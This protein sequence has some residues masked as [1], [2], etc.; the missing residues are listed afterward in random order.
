MYDVTSVE[1]SLSLPDLTN[2]TSRLTAAAF[3]S[4]SLESV[5]HTTVAVSS[6]LNTMNS[7]SEIVALRTSMLGSIADAS[8]GVDVS[9]DTLNQQATSLLALTDRP[10][11]LEDAAQETALEYTRNL[12]ASSR[13]K[14]LARGTDVAIGGV[15]SNLLGTDLLDAEQLRSNTSG[16]AHDDPTITSV[17]DAVGYLSSSQLKDRVAGESAATIQTRNIM[18]TSYRATARDAARAALSTPPNA[19]G[20][21]PSVIVSSDGADEAVI[22]TQIVQWGSNLYAGSDTAETETFSALTTLGIYNGTSSHGEAVRRHLLASDSAA[23]PGVVITLANLAPV[24]YATG[25]SEAMVNLTCPWGFLGR[26]NATCPN[27]T[28]RMWRN[29]SGEAETFRI[30]CATRVEPSCL[31][32]DESSQQYDSTR[33]TPVDWTEDNTTCSCEGFDGGRSSFTSG[34]LRMLEYFADTFA[35]TFSAALF[36]KNLLLIYTFAAVAGFVLLNVAVGHYRDIIDAKEE[37]HER[38]PES[39]SHLAGYTRTLKNSLPDFVSDKSLCV[40]FCRALR[41]NHSLLSASALAE[42]D[43]IV[44]RYIRTCVLGIG[45]LWLMAAEALLFLYSN[46]DLGC[47]EILGEQECLAMSSPYDPTVDACSWDWETLPHCNFEEPNE[48]DA[49]SPFRLGSVLLVMAFINPFIALTDWLFQNIINAPTA[50]PNRTSKRLKRGSLQPVSMKE[51]MHLVDVA[52]TPKHKRKKTKKKKRTVKDVKR[53]YQQHV[54]QGQAT[55]NVM[56]Q[57]TV[58]AYEN[59]RD[60]GEDTRD[61][62]R[63]GAFS[64]EDN[65][66]LDEYPRHMTGMVSETLEGWNPHVDADAPRDSANMPDV[67]DPHAAAHNQPDAVEPQKKKKK[68]ARRQST[69]STTRYLT[70]RLAHLPAPPVPH[71][72]ESAASSALPD[73]EDDEQIEAFCKRVAAYQVVAVMARHEELRQ[74]IEFLESES[75]PELGLVR[76]LERSFCKQWGLLPLSKRK[77]RMGRFR[78]LL[79][80]SRA[81]DET[82][83]ERLARRV[84]RKVRNDV[85]QALEWDNELEELD[86]S[87]REARFIELARFEYL[88]PTEQ[89]ARLSRAL[90][91]ACAL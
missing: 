65:T 90:T 7:T 11:Q 31:S 5:F 81:S 39:P 82:K 63:T 32:W 35:P 54:H 2:L 59:A 70:Q 37:D 86:E 64:P 46:P 12:A 22:S 51:A 1:S 89:Q 14:G 43:P 26:V 41:D 28:A 77:T 52:S 34:S 66:T 61:A 6:L 88:S 80:A 29:C 38:A 49:Y 57:S 85:K 74:A 62:H 13:A 67:W 75:A 71:L 24:D 42:Y 47:E 33:C 55:R 3:E 23:P 73:D 30:A 25:A 15:L 91:R 4:G 8:D 53:K 10:S 45:L 9:L 40:T 83:D 44:P 19:G 68:R 78:A 20:G 69:N 72:D 76:S 36:L 50:Q 21:A 27:S 79:E 17:L 56:Q 60:G 87:E 18:M 84:N 58:E 48:D 16:M